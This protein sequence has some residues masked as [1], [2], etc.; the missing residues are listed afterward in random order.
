MSH[1]DDFLE[2][3]RELSRT[4]PTHPPMRREVIRLMRQRGVIKSG[5]VLTNTILQLQ[6]GGLVIYEDRKFYLVEGCEVPSRAYLKSLQPNY[7]ATVR[8]LTNV[9]LL[10]KQQKGLCW[11]CGEELLGVYHVDHRMPIAKGGTNDLGNLCLACPQCNSEK[12][13]KL[14]FKG[15]LL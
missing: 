13:D 3:L 9:Q 14:Y 11:W 1:R 4:D 15:R 7:R 2:T 10:Y 6:I 12:S 5:N 8:T